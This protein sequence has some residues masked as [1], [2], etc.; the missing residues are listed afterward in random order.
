MPLLMHKDFQH[1]EQKRSKKECVTPLPGPK[2]RRKEGEK[3]FVSI[4]LMCW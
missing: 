3:K 1:F 4:S 2:E